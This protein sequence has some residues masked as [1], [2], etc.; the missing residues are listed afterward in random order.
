MLMKLTPYLVL[1]GLKFGL[2]NLKFVQEA[3]FAI[4]IEL[5]R[6]N[7]IKPNLTSSPSLALPVLS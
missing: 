5:N 6:L 2:N 7:Q 1:F 4:I 3:I